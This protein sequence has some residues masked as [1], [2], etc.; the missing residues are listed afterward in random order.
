MYPPQL[1]L[2]V[3]E[4]VPYR[5]RRLEIV[6]HSSEQHVGHGPVFGVAGDAVATSLDPVK[7]DRCGRS[8]I[9]PAGDDDM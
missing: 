2:F 8:A 6:V 4:E 1:A 7:H 3:L 5:V 9:R